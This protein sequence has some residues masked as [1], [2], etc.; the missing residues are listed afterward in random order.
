MP[1]AACEGMGHQGSNGSG[2]GT[3]PPQGF[4]SESTEFLGLG[5]VMALCAWTA[6]NMSTTATRIIF[7]P[8]Q[9]RNVFDLFSPC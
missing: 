3:A 8:Q 4:I 6:G 7:I 5:I 1:A 9:E 2:V